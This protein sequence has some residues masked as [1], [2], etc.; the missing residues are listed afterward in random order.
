MRF[1]YIAGVKYEWKSI[2]QLRREQI[3]AARKREPKDKR[4]KHEKI[5]CGLEQQ[6]Q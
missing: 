5:K 6:K 4:E 1:I 3:A 2:R